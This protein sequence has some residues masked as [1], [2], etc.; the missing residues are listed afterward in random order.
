MITISKNSYLKKEKMDAFL[1]LSLKNFNKWRIRNS[2]FYISYNPKDLQH[3][4]KE[5]VYISLG[6][7]FIWFSCSRDKCYTNRRYRAIL[8]DADLI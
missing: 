6:N 4:A 8:V 1:V 2:H 3:W 7:I 5:Q